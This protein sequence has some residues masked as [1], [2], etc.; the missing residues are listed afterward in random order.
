LQ[1]AF[2]VD[3][4]PHRFELEILSYVYVLNNMLKQPTCEDKRDGRSPVSFNLRVNNVLVFGLFIF[5][6]IDALIIL[7][8]LSILSDNVY[9]VRLDI[10][11]VKNISD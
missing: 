10:I 1:K 9:P 8:L 5:E 4:D 2:R 6:S 3:P 7:V 11:R